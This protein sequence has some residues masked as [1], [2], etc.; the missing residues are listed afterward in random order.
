MYLIADLGSLALGSLASAT[1]DEIQ[2]LVYSSPDKQRLPVA[3][4]YYNSL[5]LLN[6]TINPIIQ[7]QSR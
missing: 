7:P 3:S 2:L 6:K 1:L 4:S 5:L